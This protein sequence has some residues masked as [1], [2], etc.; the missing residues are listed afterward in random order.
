MFDNIEKKKKVFMARLRGIQKI[1]DSKH[2][3]SFIKLDRKIRK[4][5]ENLLYQEELVWFHKFREDWICSGD[6]NTQFYHAVT[7]IR[8]T[9]NSINNLRD[10]TRNLV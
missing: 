10:E 7:V 6:M 8:R 5:L 2:D 4:D 3:N 9:R 1:L